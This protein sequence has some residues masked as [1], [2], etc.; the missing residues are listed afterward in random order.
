ME[1]KKIVVYGM[2]CKKCEQL[3]ANA[4]EA[5]HQIGVPT[6][7]EY[8]TDVAIV[9]SAGIMSTPA[10]AIDGKVVSSGSVLAPEAIAELIEKALDGGNPSGG[11]CSCGGRC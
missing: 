11:A 9:A 1:E 4:L 8:I 10:L 5:A 3:H 7:V 2:G 6:R